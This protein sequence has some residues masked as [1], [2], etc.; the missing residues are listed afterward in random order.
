MILKTSQ[1][2]LKYFKSLLGNNISNISEENENSPK[3][4]KSSKKDSAYSF[5]LS[6]KSSDKNMLQTN[7]NPNNHNNHNSS[8][9]MN[10]YAQHTNY[11]SNRSTSN[12][13]LKRIEN[14]ENQE[15][16]IA[17]SPLVTEQTQPE[18]PEQVTQPTQQ[19]QITQPLQLTQPIEIK[20]KL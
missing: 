7:Y 4:P 11:N 9:I 15:I 13:F 2:Q 19:N 3:P 17:S 20:E 14:T 10:N 1:E 5:K 18:D 6:N 8:V 16:P 12:N